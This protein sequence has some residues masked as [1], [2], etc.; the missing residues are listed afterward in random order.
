M[1]RGHSF[2]ADSKKCNERFGL[3]FVFPIITDCETPQI[4]TG[5]R[6]Q[7]V[8][9]KKPDRV[10]LGNK[11]MGA[12]FTRSSSSMLA[13]RRLLVPITVSL[14]LFSSTLPAEA[15]VS[16]ADET[17]C[18][19]DVIDTPPLMLPYIGRDPT[20]LKIELESDQ[21]DLPRPGVLSLSGKSSVIQGAQA[22]F[23]D[24]IVF[25][26]EALSLKSERAVVH[27]YQG[28][29][30]TASSLELDLETR[31]GSAEEVRFQIAERGAIPK[32][33]IVDPTGHSFDESGFT[34]AV[35]GQ[36]G[37]VKGPRSFHLPNVVALPTGELISI[38]SGQKDEGK[39]AEEKDSEPDFE[40]KARSRG[41]AQRVYFEGHD[42]E[43][44]EDV[45]YSSCV[46]GDDTVLMKAGEIILDHTTGVGTGKNLSVRFFD[47]P[48]LYF[49]QASFPINDERKSGLLFPVFGYG[50]D[51]GFNF[52]IPYYWNIA[53]EQDA[54]FEG[55]MMANRG[56]QLAGEYRYIGKSRHGDH[57]GVLR[58]EFMPD[59]S[60]FGDSRY[61]WSYEHR[62]NTRR[63]ETDF[64]LD[65]DLGYV[66]DTAYLDDLADDLQVSSAAHIPQIID[67]A[68]DPYDIF[69]EDENLAVNVDASAYQSLDTALQIEQEPYA[70]LPGITINWSKDFDLTLDDSGA[71][72]QRDDSTE[73]TV[74]P[75][76]DSELVNFQHSADGMTKG[77]RLD[78]Q[79]SLALPMERVYGAITPKLTW[80]YTAYSVSD[81]PQGD[82]SSPMRNIFL[83]EVASELFLERDVVWRST[84]HVQTLVPRLSY[85]YVPFEDQSDLPVFDSGS[86]GFGN[87]ADA[88]LS[89]GF[90]GSDRI[91]DFQ[92]F[93]LGLESETYGTESGDRLMKW[94]LAQQI[95]LADREVTLDPADEPQTSDYSALLGEIDFNFS[96]QWSAGGFASWDWDAIELNQWRFSSS[97]SPDYRRE[98]NLAYQSEGDNTSNVELGLSW[99]LAPRWQL[100]AAGLLGQ[101][102]DDGQYTRVSVGYDACCWALRVQ[103]E[104]RPRKDDEQNGESEGGT[105]VMV[106]LKLKGL[107]KISSGELMGLSQGFTTAAPS[108]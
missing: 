41:T 103:L 63:W 82:P 58:G 86:V 84:E 59:D 89:D 49:P 61:G 104:D 26:K 95:Y 32:T 108:L 9:L 55:H 31:V 66:S 97:F 17:I 24:R 43:R 75:E 50:K 10:G 42:R 54:T 56:L 81:Q 23:A 28:D 18:P 37:S 68:I 30:I 7:I 83:F 88:Y 25:D 13:G 62:L 11:L 85:H 67:L 3:T 20:G 8:D 105:H 74:R 38:D 52:R 100:G 76:V 39:S 57:N 102:D 2:Q 72:Y 29:K 40:V 45:I 80:A 35:A 60:K 22:I 71:G 96:K 19:D 93:T 44:L 94:T 91:Q 47:V 107:G 5:D 21:I 12:L 73:F 16:F 70:R 6:F 69:L 65:I 4:P 1:D 101:G 15:P 106:T 90:W 48:I 34:Y 99:P 14:F 77:L 27:S 87:I 51:W 78:I 53:P 33:S 64:N 46:A 92:G 36:I 79:P 98:L